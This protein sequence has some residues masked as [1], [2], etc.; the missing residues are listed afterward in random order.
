MKKRLALALIIAILPIGLNPVYAAPKKVTITF[1]THDNGPSNTFERILIDEYQKANPNVTVNYL[2]VPGAQIV[3]K[4]A[5]SIAGGTGPDLVNVIKRVVPQLAS[6]GLLNPVDFSSVEKVYGPKYKGLVKSKAYFNSMYSEKVRNAFVWDKVQI[7]I[8]HEVASYTLFMNTS[9]SSKAGITTVPKTWTEVIKTCKAIADANPGVAPIVLP[10]A[11]S[12]QM[13]QVFDQIV[14]AAGGKLISA[15]GNTPYLDSAAVIRALSL[16]RDLVKTH[17]CIDPAVGPIAGATASDLFAQGKTALNL[18]SA[19]WYV[20]YL[21]TGYPKVYENYAVGQLPKFNVNDK[22]AGGTI[23]SYSLLVPKTSKQ[24]AEAWKFGMWLSSK[25]Q[26]YFDSTGVW[27]GDLKTF[28][29]KT[30]AASEN[31]AQFKEAIDTGEFLPNVTSYLQW[32]DIVR[33]MIEAVILGSTSPE[34]A[35]RTAQEAAVRLLYN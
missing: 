25:G 4:L 17:N 13:Y 35:A 11:S 6:K 10:L 2:P 24:S 29:S 34:D 21:K 3:T 18:S 30:T 26:R 14:R 16:W 9:F 32:T 15:N 27:L 8:P 22:P 28:N 12:G 5:T 19:S 23:Y 1:W 33:V 20:P 7:G 31:W